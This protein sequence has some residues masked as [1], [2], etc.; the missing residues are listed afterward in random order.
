MLFSFDVL[1]YHTDPLLK[2]NVMQKH[3]LKGKAQ[4]RYALNTNQ[5]HGDWN[6]TLKL[7]TPRTL[8]IFLECV[9]WPITHETS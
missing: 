2:V 9:F 3:Y 1:K 7:R 4:M 5:K 6:N 8:K